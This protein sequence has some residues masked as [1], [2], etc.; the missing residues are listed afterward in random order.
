MLWC[1]AIFWRAL[2]IRSYKFD[3]E[4]KQELR[5]PKE[6]STEFPFTSEHRRI[7]KASREAAADW[8]LHQSYEGWEH[9][10]EEEGSSTCSWNRQPNSEDVAALGS[11]SVEDRL[12]WVPLRL[13]SPFARILHFALAVLVE[14]L[15]QSDLFMQIPVEYLKH[16]LIEDARAFLGSHLADCLSRWLCEVEDRFAAGEQLK[17]L[18]SLYTEDRELI[19]NSKQRWRPTAF[20]KTCES[21]YSI[22]ARAIQLEGSL[23]SRA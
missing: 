18:G 20:T 11:D 13:R 23:S 22:R 15:H 12:H 7:M 5:S 10:Q 8:I 9:A 1:I 2:D 14:R 6:F 4:D 17:Q 21:M 19:A 3:G 16:W